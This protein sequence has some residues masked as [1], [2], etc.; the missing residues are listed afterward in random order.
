MYILRLHV[1]HVA[2]FSVLFGRLV[3]LPSKASSGASQDLE[4]Q[5]LIEGHIAFLA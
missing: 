2:V 5:A 1:I 3:G 4:A